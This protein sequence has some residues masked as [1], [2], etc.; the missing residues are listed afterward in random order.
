[1]RVHDITNDHSFVRYKSRD[2]IWSNDTPNHW[3]LNKPTFQLLEPCDSIKRGHWYGSSLVEVCNRMHITCLDNKCW[4]VFS[5]HQGM[6]TYTHLWNM[7]SADS[8]IDPYVQSFS[9][10]VRIKL[11]YFLRTWWP[12]ASCQ[13]WCACVVHNILLYQY[14][15]Y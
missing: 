13:S 1:M 7:L 6:L 14:T 11:S 4:R 12:S 8:Y 5:F 10:F 2:Y 3:K 9:M 15:I